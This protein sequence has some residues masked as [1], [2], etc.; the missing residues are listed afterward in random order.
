MG[1]FPWSQ[2]PRTDSENGRKLSEVWDGSRQRGDS[3]AGPHGCRNLTGAAS[4]IAAPSPQAPSR[5]RPGPRRPRSS[6]RLPLLTSR[7][8]RLT[9]FPSLRQR[10]LRASLPFGFTFLLPTPGGARGAELRMPGGRRTAA[11]SSAPQ[12]RACP[13]PL[14]VPGPRHAWMARRSLPDRRTDPASRDG[15]EQA[16]AHASPSRGGANVGTSP[17]PAPPLPRARAA[18]APPPAR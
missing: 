2:P 14:P 4:P 18:E 12:R 16:R 6:P 3:S 7:P 15:A 10:P 1:P 13:G 9:R 5:Q 8:A 11:P 17:P